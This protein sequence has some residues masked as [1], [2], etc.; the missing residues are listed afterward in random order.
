MSESFN[1]FEHIMKALLG[2]TGTSVH[3]IEMGWYL[4]IKEKDSA[5]NDDISKVCWTNER[6]ALD[7]QKGQ[8]QLQYSILVFTIIY[9]FVI[10]NS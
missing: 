4:Q 2:F 3:G 6:C 10:R 1:N 8:S 5:R 7:R 9:R